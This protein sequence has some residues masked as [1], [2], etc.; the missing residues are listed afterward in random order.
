MDGSL[1]NKHG[2]LLSPSRVSMEVIVM[3]FDKLVYS[4]FAGLTADL[5]RGYNPFTKYQGHPSSIPKLVS[6]LNDHGNRWH[7]SPFKWP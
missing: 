2:W 4:L 6:V 5:Y 1:V 7:K 3:I